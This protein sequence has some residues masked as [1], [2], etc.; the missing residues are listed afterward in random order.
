MLSCGL[1]TRRL[2]LK[3]NY[4]TAVDDEC[5]FVL[6]CT[7]TLLS[8]QHST[9][10]H[11]LTLVKPKKET[12]ALKNEAS[13]YDPTSAKKKQ[14]GSGPTIKISQINIVSSSASVEYQGNSSSMSMK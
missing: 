14:L 10:Y 4:E 2:E 13:F 9:T 7:W 1:F 12:F 3:E 11:Q 6:G 5:L 8:D